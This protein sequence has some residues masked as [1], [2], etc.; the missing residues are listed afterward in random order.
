MLAFNAFS[1]FSEMGMVS[2]AF[3]KGLSPLQFSG[4]DFTRLLRV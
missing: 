2:I 1:S 3:K 4:L